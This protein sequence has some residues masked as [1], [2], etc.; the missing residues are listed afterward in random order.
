MTQLSQPSS[1]INNNLNSGG[2]SASPSPFQATFYKS[3]SDPNPASLQVSWE[4]MAEALSSHTRTNCH[5]CMGHDCRAK[6]G[7]GWSPVDIDGTRANV[8]VRAVTAA[9][10]DLDQITDD[11]VWDIAQKIEGFE[12]IVHSTHSHAPPLKNALRLV[13]PFTVPV[14]PVHWAGVL[15]AIISVFQFPI[16]TEDAGGVD[17]VCKD[18]S[19]FYFLPT[20]AVGAPTLFERGRGRIIDPVAL[21]AL[22]PATPVQLADASDEADESLDNLPGTAVSDLGELRK[23]LAQVRD[24]KARSTNP[25]DR[26]RHEVLQ[27]ILLSQ[28]LAAPGM[29]DNTVNR[30]ATLI[31]FA[32]PA[33]TPTAAAMVIMKPS[34]QAM[35]TEPEGFDYWLLKA[36]SCY[37]RAVIR[38]LQR[39]ADREATNARLRERLAGMARPGGAAASTPKGDK[40][41]VEYTEA[42]IAAFA[43]KA[44]CTVEEFLCRWLIQKGNSAYVF[45]GAEGYSP[46]LLKTELRAALK[47]RDLARVPA[48]ERSLAGIDWFEQ[49][50]RVLRLKTPEELLRDYATV[51][52]KVIANMMLK[53]SYYDAPSKVFHEAVCRPRLIVP[54]YDAQVDQ[55]LR[56]LGG[57]DAEKLLDWVA[58]VTRLD[59]ATCALYIF[60]PKDAGKTLLALAL[61]QLWGHAPTQLKALVGNFNSAVINCPLVLADESIPA[62]MTSGF[63][64]Q[65]I[66]TTS[67]ELT[68]KFIPEAELLGALRLIITANTPDLLQFDDEDFT[69]DDIDAIAAR[70]LYIKPTLGAPTADGKATTLAGEFLKSI[71][72]RSG[73]EGWVENGEKIAAHALWL[74]D[75]RKVTVGSRFLVEGEISDMHRRLATQGA[76]RG[77]VIEWIA[78][79]MMQPPAQ[80]GNNPGLLF[81]GGKLYV[82]ASYI[83]DQW[84]KVED[85]RPAPS[86]PRIGKALK[87]LSHGERRLPCGEG[88]ADFY[89]LKVPMILEA[90]R[91]LQVGTIE[92]FTR[93]HPTNPRSKSAKFDHFGESATRN[94]DGG[95]RS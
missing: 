69:E 88:R 16:R 42:E 85:K 72:G 33:R 18:V 37:E 70:I 11:Q 66:G 22:P 3:H 39:D 4:E 80:M 15:K 25:E 65:L 77:A 5:P 35:P 19:R 29:R 67:R 41:V 7:P 90:I 55:W 31:A 54:A 43:A 62:K 20:A 1:I 95:G 32:L 84:T 30:A 28:P 91:G 94:L 2:A 9:V 8:N 52:D 64:R 57:A 6:F 13:M 53:E 14:P 87:P 12:Y 10:L 74:R 89:D 44:G 50:G 92:D 27:R 34:L 63:L 49:V 46:P 21:L 23:R 26:E 47:K 73:T 76:V 79:V 81:G 45:R 56:L 83:K 71:G 51:A 93:T 48:P 24:R 60:G 75:N 38:R 61:A 86:L 68:R 82:N 59:R 78:K 58:T 40:A 36:A 17:P